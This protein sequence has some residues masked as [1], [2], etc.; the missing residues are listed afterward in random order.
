VTSER[1]FAL[2][3]VMLV[4]ALLGTV[5]AEFAFSMRLEA[6]MVRSLKEDVAGLHLAEAA[7]QQA[8]REILT[9]A[10]LQGFVGQEPLLTF[11][12]SPTQPLPRL[13]RS[14][15]KLGAGQFAYRVTDEERRLNLNTAPPDRV[16]RLL[17]SLGLDKEARDTINDSLQD[18]KDPDDVPRLNGAE[19]ED[20]YLRLPVPYRA[21]NGLLEEVAELLQIKG[22]TPSL[23]YGSAGR[24]GLAELVTVRGDG[25]VNINTASEPV[26]KTLGL[27]EAEVSEIVQSRQ[28]APYAVVPTRFTA[29]GL[30]AASHTYR[31]E[32]AGWVGGSETRVRVVAIVQRTADAGTGEPRAVILSWNPSPPGAP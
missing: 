30:S 13:P 4:L 25:Q 16:D 5:V 14:E 21:R 32:A 27:S 29:R 24:P 3:A 20:T 7:V 17:M 26:L 10:K 23:Y 9:D 2:L 18:W 11:F 6:T 31:I 19:S 22:V 28:I 12:R 1:G 8:I 15:V